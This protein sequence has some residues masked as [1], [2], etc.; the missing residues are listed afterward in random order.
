M[1]LNQ[2]TRFI[3]VKTPLGDVLALTDF[4]GHEELSRLFSFQLE[5]TSDQSN[6]D[7]TQIVGKNVTVTL[8]ASDEDTRYFNGFISQFVADYGD[9]DVTTFRAEMVPWLW[10]LTQTADCRIFQDKTFPEIITAIFDDLG[11]SDYDISGI[12]DT[13]DKHVYCVQYRETDFNFVS[14]LAEQE[15]IFYY[16]K[17]EDGKHTLVLADRASAYKDLP[18]KEVECPLSEG[19]SPVKDHITSWE[20][21]YAFVSGAGRRPTTTSKRPV[22]A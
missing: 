13:H 2:A 9:G 18:E 14:R 4:T 22:R 5:M 15:G 20:H 19:A 6:I 3:S 11:F 16:F 21:Q 12:K 1:A 7:A 10:F 17:H 8:T